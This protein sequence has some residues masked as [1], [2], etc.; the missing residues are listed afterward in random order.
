[1]MLVQT[2][3]VVQILT[4]RDS[5]WSAAGPRRRPG[6][7]APALALPPP[8]HAGR[9]P[10]RRRR[11]RDLLAAARLDEPGAHRPRP[12]RAALGLHGQRPRSGAGSPASACSRPPRNAP[13]PPLAGGRA[14]GRGAARPRP[15]RRDGL[16][17][18]LADPAA[19]ARHL[20]WLDAP[21]SRPPG[22][23]DAA[24]ASALLKLSDGLDLDRLDARE[25]YRRARLAEHPRRPRPRPRRPARR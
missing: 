2:S 25:A 4:G 5:G 10:A 20:A 16:A 1:M 12:R 15:A 8:P 22:E 23:P 21:T 6:A 14:R 13:R 17:A 18:L 7:L 24:L 11:R 19:L 9:R 3:S